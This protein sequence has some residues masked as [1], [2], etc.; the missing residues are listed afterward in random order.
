MLRL[1]LYYSS[2]IETAVTISGRKRL[3]FRK[4]LSFELILIFLVS[5]PYEFIIFAC[6]SQGFIQNPP[7]LNK[8]P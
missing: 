3:W 4:Q 1:P 5:N 2:L 6:F 8:V 7:K